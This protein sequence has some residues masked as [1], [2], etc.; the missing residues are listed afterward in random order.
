MESA[1]SGQTTLSP[2]QYN[3]L[4]VLAGTDDFDGQIAALEAAIEHAETELIRVWVPLAQKDYGHFYEFMNRDEEVGIDEHGNTM[5]G[6]TLSKHQKL[7]AEN[8]QAAAD[9]ELLRCMISM[10]PG[11][12]K[13]THC[14]HHF[15]AW[16]LGRNPK[17]RYLQAGHSQDFVD[18]EMGAKV[19]NIITSDDYGHVFPEIGIAQDMRAKGYWALNNGRGKYVAKGVGQGISGFRGQF[20][21]VD[22]PYKNRQAAESATI[23][24][25]VYQWFADDFSTRLL[26]G[27]PLFIVMTR[28]HSDDICGR[29]TELEMDKLKSLLNREG[30]DTPE[31]LDHAILSQMVE[32]LSAVDPKDKR[33]LYKIVNLPAIAEDDNDILGR[34]RGEALWPELFNL[35]ELENFKGKMTAPS[36]NSLYQGTPIDIDGGMVSKGW[37]KEYESLPAKEDIK[38]ITLSVDTASKQNERNDFTVIGVWFQ[39][40]HNNHYLADVYRDQ[41]TFPKLE[42]QI[43][44]MA[45][46]WK[47]NSILV[48]DK[49]NGTAYIQNHHGK[50][51]APAPIIAIE[52]G[53]NSKEF[54]FDKVTPMIESGQ[55]YLPKNAS[56]LPDYLKE[57]VAFPNGKNDDQVDMTSQ[58]LDHARKG[59]KRGSRKLHGTGHR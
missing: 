20:A 21:G 13:S 33:F 58:Y 7:I 36:W 29:L 14:S 47:A 6:F 42:E 41:P 17:K 8:L 56:W 43:A 27:A 26:P 38:R 23:R 9:G 49:G 4:R 22:D 55:V 35:E 57:L 48:E 28:W 50:S 12:C 10:P 34:R 30:I 19:R 15:P 2:Q 39:D 53:Q 37:F 3:A 40:R 11:H 54:R 52:V 24:E 51:T 16:L 46:R 32:K 44:S 45:T 1:L 18:N 59:G 5:F 31:K 25:T